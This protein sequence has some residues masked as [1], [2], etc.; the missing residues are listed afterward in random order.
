VG[1]WNLEVA[2][3][4]AVAG[5]ARDVGVESSTCAQGVSADG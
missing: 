1:L 3:D 5:L 2:E 4:E